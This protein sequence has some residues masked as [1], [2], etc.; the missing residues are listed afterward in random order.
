MMNAAYLG[1]LSSC[2][3]RLLFLF[4]V[5]FR[6]LSL[7]RGAP[8]RLL[9][10]LVINQLLGSRGNVLISYM[11]GLPGNLELLFIFVVKVIETIELLRVLKGLLDILDN[12]GSDATPMTPRTVFGNIRLRD[13]RRALLR[14]R[15]IQGGSAL[16]VNQR[17]IV[18]VY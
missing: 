7:L 13:R 3:L 4:I 17:P 14:E 18:N 16:E 9:F 1:L 15:R 5:V 12:L 6:L 11:A 10:L 2:L 8:L